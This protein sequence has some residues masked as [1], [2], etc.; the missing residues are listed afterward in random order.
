GAPRGPPR[1]RRR[2]TREA[3]PRARPRAGAVRL[4]RRGEHHPRS[5]AALNLV[6]LGTTGFVAAPQPTCGLVADNWRSL[7]RRKDL[8][9]AAESAAT[10]IAAS[11]M[12]IEKL[13]RAQRCRT[14]K[15]PLDVLADDTV[16]YDDR[17][18]LVLQFHCPRCNAKTFVYVRAS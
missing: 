16:T 14:C 6:L 17:E 15:G 7:P 5:G 12:Q 8:A 10:A 13:R 4:P 18:L 9:A 3:P 11:R 1:R 2:G